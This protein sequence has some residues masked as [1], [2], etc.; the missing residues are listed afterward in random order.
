MGGMGTGF[1]MVGM[2]T[3]LNANPDPKDALVGKIKAFQRQGDDAKAVWHSFCDSNCGGIY[4][5]SRHDFATLQTFIENNGLQNMNMGGAKPF[6]TRPFDPVFNELV[7]KIKNYQRMGD[8]QRT[9][10]HAF[11]DTNL[12]GK[13]DPSRASVELLQTFASAY[14]L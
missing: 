1:A 14:G 5:P 10:W 3:A 6:D 7:D 9:T 13:Y 4:D 11:C 8:A 2:G 12:Q